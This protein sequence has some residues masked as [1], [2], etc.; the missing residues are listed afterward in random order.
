MDMAA[1]T[2]VARLQYSP[3]VRGQKS[4]TRSQTELRLTKSEMLSMAKVKAHA[5]RANRTVV[6]RL[7]RRSVDGSESE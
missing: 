1:P 3:A 4:P 6:M 7:Y 2:A 5:T